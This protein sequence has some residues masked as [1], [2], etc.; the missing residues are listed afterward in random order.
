MR[1]LMISLIYFSLI[2]T[3]SCGQNQSGNTAT[4]QNDTL[5]NSLTDL[6]G[7]QIWQLDYYPDSLLINRS[8]N[9]NSG[10]ESAYAYN[11]Q[12]SEDSCQ[13]IGW[14]ESWWNRLKKTKDKEFKTIGDE[15][16]YWELKFVSNEKLLM[17]QIYIREGKAD[18]GKFAPYHKV[19]KLLTLDYLDRKIAKEMFAG[20]YH[21]IT[22]DTLDCDKSVTLDSDFGVKGITGITSYS[23]ET[24]IDWDFP[25]FNA[26]GFNKK[27]ESNNK[28]LSFRFSG[29]TLL[30]KDYKV[31]QKDDDFDHIEI[32]KTRIKMIKK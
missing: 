10:W 6:K 11:I 2:M 22:Y 31:I 1:H 3:V 12:F 8:I 7:S 17:R 28:G 13:F 21:V 25:V 9:D 16:Q 24:A 15:T 19:D 23:F 4:G 5:K 20:T 32:A 26:F 29:D 14:H 30:I 18:I 27:G